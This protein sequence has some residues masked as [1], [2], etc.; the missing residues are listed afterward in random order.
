MSLSI[1]RCRPKLPQ[2]YE[3]WC[4]DEAEK[5]RKCDG[6]KYLSAHMECRNNQGS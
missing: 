3:K 1:F 4:E 6:N 5:N 2:P